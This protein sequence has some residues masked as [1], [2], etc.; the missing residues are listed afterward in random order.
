V[1]LPDDQVDDQLQRPVEGVAQAEVI[2]DD[3]TQVMRL[4]L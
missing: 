2:A 1:V 4:E 3:E